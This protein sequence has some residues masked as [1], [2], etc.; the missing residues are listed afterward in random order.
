MCQYKLEGV[1]A[2]K[3][4]VGENDCVPVIKGVYESFSQCGG[5]SQSSSGCLKKR[6]QQKVEEYK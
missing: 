1:S 6:L 5:K 4:C 2:V 3:L